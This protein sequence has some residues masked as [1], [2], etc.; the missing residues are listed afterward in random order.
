MTA[1]DIDL[2]EIDKKIRTIKKAAE[3]LKRMSDNFPALNRGTVRILAS[4]KVLEINISDV[5][6]TGVKGL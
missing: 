1:Q 5:L 2:N 3:E 4:V 6:D